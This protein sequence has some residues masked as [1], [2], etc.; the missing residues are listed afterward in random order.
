MVAADAAAAVIQ[1]GGADA[2][3]SGIDA[4]VAVV[5]LIGGEFGL[6]GAD[7]AVLVVELLSAGLQAVEGE[8][9]LVVQ[10]LGN[11]EVGGAVGGDLPAVVEQAVG[12]YPAIGQNNGGSL[13]LGNAAAVGSST[14]MAW[15]GG[16]GGIGRL[17]RMGGVGGVAAAGVGAVV[18]G[19]IADQAVVSVVGLPAVD[20]QAL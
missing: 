12:L 5:G 18:L 19:G 15:V 13:G 7:L 14:G 2:E 3:A 1:F 11:G 17:G 10:L 16:R 20:G 6:L 9:G 4:A 8:F